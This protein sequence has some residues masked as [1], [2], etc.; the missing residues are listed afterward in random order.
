VSVRDE[1]HDRL[2][3]LLDGV[4]LLDGIVGRGATSVVYSAMH[5]TGRRGAM[6][7][8]HRRC[9]ADHDLRL[10]FRN[11]ARLAA[12]VRHRNVVEVWGSATT[13]DGVPVI[14]MELLEGM[15]LARYV[16]KTSP[17][18]LRVVQ[19]A[20]DL[21]D[22][23]Q[24]C[25][26][27]G[28]LHRDLKPSNAFIQNDGVLKLLD[29]GVAKQLANRGVTAGR[30]AIGTPSYMAPEQA[31]ALEHDRRTD[32]FGVGATLYA[33]FTGAVPHEGDEDGALDR[34]ARQSPSPL[35]MAAP[36]LPQSLAHAI[37]R[38]MARDPA[39]RWQTVSDFRAALLAVVRELS[40][41][42]SG[43][44]PALVRIKTLPSTPSALMY[45]REHS[46]TL[47]PPQRAG[48]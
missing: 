5:A 44:M 43:S 7:I 4:W 22:S 1:D 9:A 15:T 39:W 19:V 18:V 26:D 28:I 32:V 6:K 2:G 41:E 40:A 21:L 14:A 47:P 29:F 33:L 27:A 16:R 20:L 24:A 48:M 23:V 13:H 17:S 12:S 35:L 38:A 34:A 10:R 36:G 8:M 45:A 25:H 46:E 37:D 11:E 42:Q 31:R 30:M 3:S